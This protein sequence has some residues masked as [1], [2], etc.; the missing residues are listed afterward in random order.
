MIYLF[1]EV[2]QQK[3]IQKN[4]F[5]TCVNMWQGCFALLNYRLTEKGDNFKFC[6]W[7]RT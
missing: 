3:N 7:Y 4:F 2:K 6:S 1:T 5:F